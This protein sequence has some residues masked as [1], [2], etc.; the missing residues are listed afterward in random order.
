[1]KRFVVAGQPVS[2]SRSPAMFAAAF[3]ALGLSHRYDAALVDDAGFRGLVAE[4]EGGSL[5]GMNVTLPF[6]VRALELAG[7]ATVEAL[8]VGA[9][10]VLYVEQG[11]V[12]AD[13]TDVPA[14]ASELD[15]LGASAAAPALVLGAG[16]AA[17][18][19]VIALLSRGER[20]VVVRARDVGRAQPLLALSP[21]VTVE[22]LEARSTDNFQVVLQAT[23]AGMLGA[24][25]GDD[26]ANAVRW[27][28]LPRRAVAYD[29]VYVPSLTPFVS[30]AREEGLVAESGLG[31]LVLQ[32]A[33][34]FERFVGRPA[35]V[36]VMRAALGL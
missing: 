36:E 34:A 17:R 14:L 9:A 29:L 7:R 8:R 12:V 13:N 28:R 21:S 19:A 30:R 16:G 27:E 24:A 25:P 6:K 31:M 26:V 11:V 32:A 22:S 5:A 20:T 1:M 35:P 33:L 18:A 2:H 3:H 4:L 10:N 15:R 23:S